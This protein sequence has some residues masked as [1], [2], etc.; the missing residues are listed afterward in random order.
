MF[1]LFFVHLKR[2]LKNMNKTTK[3]IVQFLILTFN[4]FNT[5]TFTSHYN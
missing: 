3:N 5:I 1:P 4:K 2:E